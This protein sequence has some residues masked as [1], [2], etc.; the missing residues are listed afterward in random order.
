MSSIRFN[1][2]EYSSTL[3]DVLL[4]QDSVLVAIYSN[5][6]KFEEQIKGAKGRTTNI[7]PLAYPHLKNV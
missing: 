4:Y 6:E 1:S 3:K 7:I 5:R 2:Y